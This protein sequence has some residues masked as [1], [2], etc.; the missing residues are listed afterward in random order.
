[1]YVIVATFFDIAHGPHSTAEAKQVVIGPFDN[2]EE[3]CSVLD[4]LRSKH[5]PGIMLETKSP[6]RFKTDHLI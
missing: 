4:E 3:A 6:D 2:N 5:I 1:M